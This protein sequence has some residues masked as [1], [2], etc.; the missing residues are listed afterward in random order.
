[1]KI[2]SSLINVYFKIRIFSDKLFFV[3]VLDIFLFHVMRDW[4]EE[5]AASGGVEDD[6]EMLRGLRVHGVDLQGHPLAGQQVVQ[7]IGGV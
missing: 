3:P 6:F 1:M 2:I 5:G 4:A 7:E